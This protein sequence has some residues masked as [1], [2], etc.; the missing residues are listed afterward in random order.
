M[1]CSYEEIRNR[2]Q[3]LNDRDEQYMDVNAEFLTSH[4]CE[5][6]GEDLLTSTGFFHHFSFENE[7]NRFGRGIHG[8]DD[9]CFN[10]LF[11]I[12]REER[13]GDFLKSAQDE[14]NSFF[15]QTIKENVIQD[16]SFFNQEKISS[17]QIVIYL[18]HL[19]QLEANEY[20]ICQHLTFLFKEKKRVELQVLDDKHLESQQLYESTILPAMWKIADVEEPDYESIKRKPV[21]HPAA[22]IIP[23][24]QHLHINKPVEPIYDTPGLFNKKRVLAENEAKKKNYEKELENYEKCKE[25]LAKK[26]EAYKNALEQY[27]ID[28]AKYDEECR[29]REQIAQQ[30]HEKTIEELKAKYLREK[31]EV[32]KA[33]EVEKQK[34]H[35]L[36][37]LKREGAS[38]EYLE[39]EINHCKELLTKTIKAKNELYSKN[40]I[41]IKYRNMIA[42]SCFYDY[43]MAGRVNSLAGT[44]GAYNLYETETRSN[45]IITK[46]SDV[47][48]SLEAI[49][50]NQIVLYQTMNSIDQS[51]KELN[52]SIGEVINEIKRLNTSAESINGLL[53]SIDSSSATTAK[54]TSAIAQN[55]RIIAHHSEISAYYAKK[56]A[57]IADAIAFL[58]ALK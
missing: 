55:T 31:E 18:H 26:A 48:E 30:E 38:Y 19:L 9:S 14:F 49:K 47:V 56:N 15:E 28:K 33:Y 5:V 10:P 20:A 53:E 52:D 50:E 51:I 4:P 57:E 41:Y 43:F 27:N 1:G 2:L 8:L 16:D 7:Y 29:I 44:N 37:A 34:A 12:I 21:V 3:A 42:I 22:P 54:N 17:D 24:K 32:T 35:D 25:E 36:F 45:L 23:K 46:L 58:V 40:I 11:S 39:K 13:E 6:C